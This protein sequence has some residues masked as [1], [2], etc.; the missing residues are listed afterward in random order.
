MSEAG[1]PLGLYV[2]LPFCDVKCSFCHF[3]IDPGA[4]PDSRQER[5]V[6]ALV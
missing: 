2:H 4:A 6:R 1:E 5:Y 3:A